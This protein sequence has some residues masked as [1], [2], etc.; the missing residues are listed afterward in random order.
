[1]CLRLL[2]HLRLLVFHLRF[3]ER[4][5]LLFSFPLSC[6]SAVVA[7]RRLHKFL[8]ASD[9]NVSCAKL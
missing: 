5:Q 9:P 4:Y 7:V 3:L 6:L 2:H 1:M 8:K